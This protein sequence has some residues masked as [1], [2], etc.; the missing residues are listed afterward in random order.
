M[1]GELDE[2]NIN[3]SPT[4]YLYNPPE[5]RARYQHDTDHNMTMLKLTGT[6]GSQLG[7]FSWFAVHPT[8]MNN[9]N[10]LV[11]GDNKG[12]ASYLME[13]EI[14]GPTN[15]TRPGHG[16]FV[17]AFPSTNLGDVSPNTKGPHCRDT[18]LPCDTLHSTC[19]GRSEQC[20]AFGPGKDMFESCEI[21]GRK[22]FELAK[23]LFTQ[24]GHPA[25]DTVDYAHFYVRMPGLN[26]SKDGQHVGQLCSAAVGDSFAAGTTDGPGMFD[27][28]QGANSSNPFWHFIASF[29]HKSTPEEKACQAP[30]GIL[31]PTG[32]VDFPWPWA[33]DTL[34]L[35]LLR[36]GDFAII[37][38]PSELSTMSGRR[39][40]DAVK[41]QMVADGILSQDGTV[42]I[43]GLANSYADYTT[44]YEEYQA[45][46]YEAASTI[47]GPHQLQAYIQEFERLSH[48][49]ATGVKPPSAAPPRDF[50][51][52][53]INTGKGLHTDYYPSGAKYFGEVMVD[54]Q[55]SYKAGEV[56]RVM[57]AGAN[58]LNNMREQ[59]TFIKVQ[60]CTATEQAV[61]SAVPEAS[62]DCPV[63]ACDSPTI[64]P[65]SGCNVACGAKCGNTCC[66]I[67]GEGSCPPTP[68]APSP[69]SNCTSW[70]TVAEDGDWET[71]ISISKETVDVVET[72]RKWEVSWY[73]PKDI[74]PGRYRITHNGTSYD[75]PVTGSAFFTEYWGISSEFQVS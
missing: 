36:L 72:A 66:C 49:M 13:K 35:Q 9:T 40:R 53:L 50:T 6:D 69:A 14:N 32:D 25:G 8:S 30:K 12:Y 3:R 52:K 27:F 43:A 2:A 60:Q 55:A 11:S 23:D 51:D 68:P 64:W 56:A 28:T 24:S 29:L 5:E 38:V 44:T 45:Q 67:S 18:G 15:T 48:S 7:A 16:R 22:Q 46:R 20:S 10:L 65:I 70:L 42:V 33:P 74:S 19:N 73:I 31:L 54:V 21:I 37:V 75:D 34:P 71:R 58:P 63:C 61:L 41:A 26:V 17:G 47:Y 62:G 57:F 39:L 4:S 1:V 59:D